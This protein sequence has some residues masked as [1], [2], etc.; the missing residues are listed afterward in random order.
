VL[1]V[2]KDHYYILARVF[3]FA[4]LQ[5]LRLMGFY[6]FGGEPIFNAGN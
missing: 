2:G 6:R 4:G 5:V 1:W 3:R